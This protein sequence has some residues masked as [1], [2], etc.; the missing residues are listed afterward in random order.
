VA[1]VD[2]VFIDT[3]ELFRFTIMDVL[4]SLAEDPGTA[5]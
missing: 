2:K 4:L 5:P 3:S 1:S